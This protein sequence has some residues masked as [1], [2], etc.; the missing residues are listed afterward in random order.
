MVQH[1]V[2][3]GEDRTRLCR[4]GERS[5]IFRDFQLINVLLDDGSNYYIPN[6]KKRKKN[7]FIIHRKILRLF[8]EYVQISQPTA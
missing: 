3:F 8:D 4:T 1:I 5:R 6:R 7:H 2:H